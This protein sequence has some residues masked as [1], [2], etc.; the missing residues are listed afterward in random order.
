MLIYL[1]KQMHRYACRHGAINYAFLMSS[2]ARPCGHGIAAARLGACL[3]L[4]SHGTLYFS[5]VTSMRSSRWMQ[6]EGLT[7]DLQLGAPEYAVIV[8]LCTGAMVFV[9]WNWVRDSLPRNKLPAIVENCDEI[10]D[11]LILRRLKIKEPEDLRQISRLT[12]LWPVLVTKPE[13]LKIPALRMPVEDDGL[14]VI[15]LAELAAHARQKN[16]KRARRL[17]D[18]LKEIP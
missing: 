11:A 10:H 15:W 4:S 5:A 14:H 18:D 1:T 3:E 9:N 13:A 2:Y 16:I 12:R 6:P 7:M 8:T 17:V